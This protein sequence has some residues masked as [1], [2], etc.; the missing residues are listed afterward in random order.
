MRL[1]SLNLKVTF[2]IYLIITLFLDYL[3]NICHI[4]LLIA[5]IKCIS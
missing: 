5:Y 2:T 1:L 3:Y 4:S